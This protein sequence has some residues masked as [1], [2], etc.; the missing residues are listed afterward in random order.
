MTT[1]RKLLQAIPDGVEA[2]P[3]F[4]E[5]YEQFGPSYRW[6][7]ALVGMIGTFATLLTST[8]VNI[9]I[10]DIMGALGMTLEEAQWL[11]T[12]FLGAG[13]VTMLMTS[14]CIRAYGVANTYI[15]SMLV[16]VVGSFMGAAAETSE[17]LLI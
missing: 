1:T 7:A 6:W 5:K 4:L 12:G 10:P 8:I 9:A 11:A 17:T 3:G 14:W 2:S 13:T 16:F 15:F